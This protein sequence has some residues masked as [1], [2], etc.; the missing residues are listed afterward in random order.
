AA[1]VLLGKLYVCG[2]WDGQEALKCVERYDPLAG[3]WEEVEPMMQQRH[4][5][6][7]VRAANH[8]YIVGG[9][10][11]EQ[12]LSSVERYDPVSGAWEPL[13]SMEEPRHGAS[14]GRVHSRIFVFGG[15]NGTLALT[16]AESLDLAV[17]V[18]WRSIG[19]M[20]HGREGAGG[21]TLAGLIYVCG[22]L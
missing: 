5:A 14:A 18:R 6:A 11:N 4:G 19:D 9:H 1:H 17:G 20:C 21:A 16:T 7:A 3:V 13:P 22:G 2:G 15:H 10:D 12:A 8:L